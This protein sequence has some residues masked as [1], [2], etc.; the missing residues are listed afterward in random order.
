MSLQTIL[1]LIYVVTFRELDE[2]DE[3]DD[4]DRGRILEKAPRAPPLRGI[5]LW[6]MDSMGVL[7][8][9]PRGT[10]S[11]LLPNSLASCPLASSYAVFLPVWAVVIFLVLS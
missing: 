5:L 7:D 3:F 4:L 2:L 11:S 9:N 10:R 8:P 6:C 1:M